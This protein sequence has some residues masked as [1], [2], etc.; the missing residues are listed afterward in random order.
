MDLR[1]F[2]RTERSS[3]N[4]EDKAGPQRTDEPSAWANV[5]RVVLL[6]TVLVAAWFVLEWLIG[7]K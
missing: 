2:F 6:I 4:K 5:G 7:G 3:M 1:G